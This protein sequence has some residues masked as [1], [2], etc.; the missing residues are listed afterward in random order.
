MED[1]LISVIIPVYKVEK[2]LDR[3]VDSVVNQTYKNLE[4]IL[5]DDG[6]PDNCP[7]MCDEWAKKDSRIR[8]IHKGNGGVSAA[9]NTGLDIAKGEYIG[10]VDSDDYID[11]TMYEKLLKKAKESDAD[12]TMCRYFEFDENKNLTKVNEINL[13]KCDSSNIVSF[14]IND[15]YSKKDDCIVTNNV[16]GNIWRVLYKRN[17]IGEKRIEKLSFAEDFCFNLSLFIDK[18][19]IAIVDEYLYFY[20]QRKDS[21]VH[22]YDERAFYA[23]LQSSEHAVKLI[24]PLLSHE[25]F[26]I[27][28]FNQCRQLLVCAIRNSSYKK[29]MKEYKKIEWLCECNCKENYKQAQ[30]NTKDLKYK[31]ANWLVYKRFYKLFKLLYRLVKG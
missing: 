28:R 25:Q 18:P 24:E 7:A 19:R 2:Y 21:S 15:Y 5:V 1:S 8:V 13:T 16:M 20:F 31:V 4:I 23:R 30:K 26:C 10:F 12:L 17:L 3:C 22:V 11:S 27:F 6:S 29:L 9:R 14:Y